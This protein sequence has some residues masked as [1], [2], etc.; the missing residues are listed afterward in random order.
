MDLF[1]LVGQRKEA[2]AGQYSREALAVIDE[3]GDS[4]NP[5]YMRDELKKQ[6]DSGEFDA[7]AVLHLSVDDLAVDAVLYPAARV[8]P[9]TVIPPRAED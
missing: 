6:T 1:V 7:L 4:E 3:I 5:D 2:Y 9:A 8:L